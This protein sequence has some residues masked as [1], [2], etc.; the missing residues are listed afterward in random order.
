MYAFFDR[1][2]ILKVENA[3][4]FQPPSEQ[5]FRQKSR[6]L[7]WRKMPFVSQ[8]QLPILLSQ[9]LYHGLLWSELVPWYDSDI[10]SIVRP[11]TI[12]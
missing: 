6:N 3:Q 4:F 11:Y 8:L 5:F 12:A 9:A 10:P 1:P 2:F 7:R